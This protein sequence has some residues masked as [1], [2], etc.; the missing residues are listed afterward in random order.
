MSAVAATTQTTGT[1]DLALAVPKWSEAALAVCFTA[2]VI[3]KVQL[4][5]LLVALVPW[6]ALLGVIAAID[7]RELR[8]PNK[9]VGIGVLAALPAL[10]LGAVLSA[11]AVSLSRAAFAALA[12]LVLF[13]LCH[14]ASPASLGMGD[15]KLAPYISAHLGMFSWQVWYRGLFY[16]FA[17]VSVAGIIALVVARTGRRTALPFAPFMALGAILAL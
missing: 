12:G 13:G 16:G 7:F 2:A 1:T 11:S 17:L 14:L 5:W 8:V 15:V 3:A 10:A 4:D 9:L 6:A